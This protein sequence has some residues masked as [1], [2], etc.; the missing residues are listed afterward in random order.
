MLALLTLLVLSPTLLSAPAQ[1]KTTTAAPT[2]DTSVWSTRE[3]TTEMTSEMT[4]ET[5]TMTLYRDSTG[6]E[7]AVE[8]SGER[9]RDLVT[10]DLHSV[11]ETWSN[12]VGCWQHSC[13]S[14]GGRLYYYTTTCPSFYV[15]PSWTNCTEVPG[16]GLSFPE[17]CPRPS[18]QTTRPT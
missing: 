16:S 2:E 13:T 5:T 12:K 7:S 6:T 4:T 18:C 8:Q 1:E 11:G 15:P 9:C 3:T 17:C 10:G 14:L